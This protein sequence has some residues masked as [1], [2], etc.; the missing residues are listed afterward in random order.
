MATATGHVLTA[1]SL[2]HRLTTTGTSFDVN[3]R[4]QAGKAKC[5]LVFDEV[6]YTLYETRP[7][8]HNLPASELRSGMKNTTVD[9]SCTKLVRRSKTFSRPSFERRP[10]EGSLQQDTDAVLG[11][12]AYQILHFDRPVFLV[13]FRVG[14]RPH[15]RFADRGCAVEV[16]AG[17]V[18]MNSVDTGGYVRT[19]T[20]I[21]EMM[22]AMK[23][24]C[25]AG[26]I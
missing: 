9:H 23:K 20:V 5:S 1:N 15:E 8:P 7:F 21:A 16:W 18:A 14:R 13:E 10:N 6:F 12:C 2:L 22:R 4:N 19:P 26:I 3:G 25:E 11:F 24:L 17:D